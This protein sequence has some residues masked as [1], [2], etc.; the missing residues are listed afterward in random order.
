M[1]APLVSSTEAPLDLTE[2]AAAQPESP[3]PLEAARGTSLHLQQFQVQG[4]IV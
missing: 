3:Q 1:E 4:G 2:L